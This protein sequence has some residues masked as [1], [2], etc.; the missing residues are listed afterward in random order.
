[1]TDADRLRAALE[2]L[3]LSQRGFARA[4][5]CDERVIRRMCAGQQAVPAVIWLAL[6]GL[7]SR[8]PVAPLH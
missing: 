7:A 1:M 5:E 2:R 6:D 4:I 3:G 8:Q